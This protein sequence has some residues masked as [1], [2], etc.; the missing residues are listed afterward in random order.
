VFIIIHREPFLITLEDDAV[1]L[2]RYL[3]EDNNDENIIFD[4]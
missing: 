2:A 1:I 4:M 3:I